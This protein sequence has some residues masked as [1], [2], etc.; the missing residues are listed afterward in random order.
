M[1]ETSSRYTLLDR[2]LLAAVLSLTLAACGGVAQEGEG[3]DT[4]GV[5]ESAVGEVRLRLMA[6]NTTSGTLQSYDPGHGTRIFQGTRPDVVLIQE[7]NYGDNSASAIR[8]F[9]DT[10]FGSTFHYYRE[11]AAQI[12]NGVISRWPIVAAGEWDDPYVSNRDFAWARIDIPGAK[13]LWVVSVHLLTSDATTRNNE[14]TNLVSR[15]KANIP[16]SDY[17]VIGGDFNTDSRTES[18]FSTFS[19]VVTTSGPYPADRNGNTNTNAG[20]TKPYDHVLV[21]AD[22]RAYQTATVIGSS[23]FAAGLVADTRVYSPISEISPALSSD[24]GA[25]NMQ[26]QAIIKDFLIP[27]DTVSTSVTVTSPNGGESFVGGS[28]QNIT[29]T[30]S[31][32]T[33]VKLEY[34]LT[35][36]TWTVITSSTAASAGSY[37][38]TVPSSATTTAQVRVSDAANS[39]ITDTSNAAFTITTSTGGG[40]AQ[41]FINEILANE[42]GTDVNG[43]F[44]EL[45]N[46]GG[47][48]AD[49]SG[50]TVSDSTGVRHTFASGTTL[51]AGG[52]IVVFGGA[53]GI[54]SG[55]T[56]AV[57]AST[58][59]LGLGNSGDTVTVKNAAGTTVNTTT[60]ASSLAG[61]DGVSANRSPDASSG[62]TFVLHTTLSGLASSPGK[63]VSG[64]VF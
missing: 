54:P 58:G 26:H 8:G 48:A 16:T 10:T 20:R 6:A 49:L 7:F 13:D 47:T 19:Q 33:N 11:D 38:W 52:A 50:W 32:V 36:S 46:S 22:L 18:A 30:A 59:T 28:T 43:E 15:I 1:T 27:G 40:T 64:S 51:P 45:V 57:G 3:G 25:T 21:D 2:R 41:V 12:P 9:V 56:N 63:R 34:T 44:V 29:W 42:P 39:A 24:S 53:S 14:A 17:L 37:A 35:G 4:L 31:G 5:Q 61:T 23:S 62:G 55:L 60:Y